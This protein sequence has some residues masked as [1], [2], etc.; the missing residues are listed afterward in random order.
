MRNI[1]LEIGPA[2]NYIHIPIGS[3]LRNQRKGPI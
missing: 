3:S 2:N 1:L